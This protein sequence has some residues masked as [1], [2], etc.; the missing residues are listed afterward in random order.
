MQ[1][2][3]AES[4]CV[5]LTDTSTACYACQLPLAVPGLQF[6]ISNAQPMF[7]AKRINIAAPPLINSRFQCHRPTSR[8]DRRRMASRR[9]LFACDK[10]PWASRY[11]LAMP[12]LPYRR[13]AVA[14]DIS[15]PPTSNRGM[16]RVY[17]GRRWPR[18]RHAMT[19]LALKYHDASGSFTMLAPPPN[20]RCG[21]LLCGR[22]LRAD[23]LSSCA[24]PADQQQRRR[25]GII[26]CYGNSGGGISA[27]R[28]WPHAG[29]ATNVAE[30]INFIKDAD[31]HEPHHRPMALHFGSIYF[32]CHD[33]IRWRWRSEK[34]YHRRACAL[35]TISIGL[36]AL[37]E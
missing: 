24:W 29:V 16:A 31:H 3:R 21:L 25:L 9:V 8:Y 34:P 30:D 28:R 4:I 2:R 22:R 13:H 33:E 35:T 10:P 37:A 17:D 18:H 11:C 15:M 12:P 19:L 36:N 14:E 23:R 7:S 26:S 1:H 27:S 5:H 20:R 6:V 32:E